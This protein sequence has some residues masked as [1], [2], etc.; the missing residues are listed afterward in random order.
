LLSPEAELD[1]LRLAVVGNETKG[2]H[3]PAIDVPIRAYGTV[4]AHRPEKRVERRC[5]LREEVPGTI[6]SSGGLRYLLV[7]TRLDGMD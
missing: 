3:T 6:M 7:W 5:L 2:V 4:A 1:E